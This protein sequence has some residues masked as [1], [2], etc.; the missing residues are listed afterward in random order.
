MTAVNAAAAVAAVHADNHAAQALRS[1]Y[2]RAAAMLSRVASELIGVAIGQRTADTLT[3]LARQVLDA[4][5][6]RADTP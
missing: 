1:D 2:Y 4:V 3:P 5:T 6:A